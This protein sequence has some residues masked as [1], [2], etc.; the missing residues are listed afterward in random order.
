MHGVA[1]L[2]FL[3]QSAREGTLTNSMNI[4][5][6][7]QLNSIRKSLLKLTGDDE[8][9]VILAMFR[10]GCGPDV[11]RA[12]RRPINTFMDTGITPH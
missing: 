1:G 9:S 2:A 10:I 8:K 4:V 3:L 7:R 11:T 12:L 6:L 5:Q